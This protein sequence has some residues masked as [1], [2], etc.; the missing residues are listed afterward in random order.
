MASLKQYLR[1]AEVIA[2]LLLATLILS[3]AAPSPQ[4]HPRRPEAPTSQTSSSQQV[5]IQTTHK[6]SDLST[7]NTALNQTMSE[8]NA[9]SL[10]PVFNLDRGDVEL[11]ENLGAS[12][13]YVVTIAGSAE[14]DEAVAA[15]ADTPEIEHAEP[16]PIGH[17]AWMPDDPRLEDQWN[18]H[19][20]GQ[21]DSTPEADVDAPEAWDI[22]RGSP[23]TVL[24]VIDTGIDLDHPDLA[25]KIVEGYNVISDTTIPQD[26]NGHGTHVAGIAVATT[27]NAIGIAGVCPRC[28]VMPL[29]ALNSDNLGYYTDWASAIEHAVDNGAHM[30]NMSMGG[31]L[32]S[33]LLHTA[34]RYAYQSNVP[35]VVSMMNEGNSTPYY[36]AV[37]TETI[38]VGATDRKGARWEQSCFGD[39]I[40][41][42]APGK[43]ILSTY[44]DDS[45]TYMLGTSMAA[46]HVAGALGLIH[47]VHPGYTIEESRHILRTT[48]DDQ[49]G[50]PNEDKK[51]WD[52]YFGAGQL[53]LAQA[54]QRAVPPN[55]T[56]I[57]GPVSGLVGTD[58]T[59]VASVVPITAAQ[60][61]TYVWRAT[62]QA[63]ITHTSGL[64]DSV[65]FAWD[66]AGAKRITLTAANTGGTLT[67]THA[68]TITEL[69]PG[70]EVTVCNGHTCTFDAIQAAIDAV[71]AS[72]TIK[73]AAGTYTGIYVDKSV[74]IRGGY[75]AAF[76]EPADPEANL[77]IIDAQGGGR[78][79]HITGQ[80]TGSPITPTIEGLWLT[81]GDASGQPGGNVGGGIYAIE[82]SPIISHNH[83]VS[84][85]ARR[86]AGIYL[87]ESTGALHG[88]TIAHN[89]AEQDG[90]GIYLRE[91]ETIIN[92][93]EIASNHAG[94]G[95]GGL[96]AY[97]SDAPISDNSLQAN[98]A[99]QDGGGLYLWKSSA[100]LARNV[101]LDNQARNGGGGHLAYGEIQM[102]NNVIASNQA[103]DAGDGLYVQNT[104]P[105]LLH[106]TL[107]RNGDEG[108]HV[109]GGESLSTVALTNT[110]LTD[111]TT[112]IVATAEHVVSL[113]GTLWGNNTSD[114]DG[115]GA[116]ITG[117]EAN[118]H[119]GDPAFV[120]PDEGD[121]HIRPESPAVDMALPISVTDDMDGD[122]RPTSDG[123]DLGADELK[124]DLQVT[125]HASSN[126]ALASKPLTHTLGVTNVGGLVMETVITNVPPAHVTP[127]DTRTWH[128]SLAPG[129]AWSTRLVVT[130]ATDYTGPLV[131]IVQ[132][133]GTEGV[134]ASSTTTVTA[135]A[136]DGVTVIN[137]ATGTEI[138]LADEPTSIVIAVPSGALSEPAE[139]AYGSVTTITHAP[140]GFAFAGRAFELNAY[141]DG[142]LQ[143]GLTFETP[144][145]VTIGY[146]QADMEGKNEASLALYYWDG[147]D[148]TTDGITPT[149]HYPTQRQ[150][151]A[152]I[153]H[154]STFAL[155]ARNEP[156][157]PP[158]TIY[159]PLV[160]RRR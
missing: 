123:Y 58:R 88:N 3:A 108:L 75:S 31:D 38:A 157:T 83:I 70:Q 62:A 46:P 129:E 52:V 122:P 143:E 26:D 64:T 23:S 85:T 56:S 53:N 51:G 55:E 17:G 42:V 37:Y 149:A 99:D 94:K 76:K 79:V 29:K 144:L 80:P 8:F 25:G 78:A 152:T 110:I 27:N 21:M 154:L 128:T 82:A 119:R 90:G 2:L 142:I 153:D 10:S 4:S 111:H 73:V 61:I 71:E 57:D 91:S 115:A 67:T 148:W 48:A 139:L 13:L 50:P 41:L 86:G 32:D 109:T 102:V 147:T 20:T 137:P 66:V 136:A 124:V 107:A 11:K 117:T 33:T 9:H 132:V 14:L 87:E 35:V 121:Y 146:T 69:S 96:Y 44:W 81:G 72:N 22:S 6:P 120:A 54:L 18:L 100:N 65:T 130:V 160:L 103:S 126:P 60:P 138:T 125:Q 98:S 118:N 155:L 5:I 141:R 112:G 19:S 131:N 36:P 1:Q 47:S 92:R 30:I 145:T 59:F 114:W 12:R 89:E 40:D 151:I 97:W 74:I 116:V 156:Q 28:R 16:D 34:I 158:G 45:Y 135:I 84:N 93:N 113:E 39:H 68:L 106:T 150:L 15:F 159:L 7:L 63:P 95:G 77:T 133:E 134:T 101:I 140:P 24:A 49:I 43:S 105:R 127:A 104:S